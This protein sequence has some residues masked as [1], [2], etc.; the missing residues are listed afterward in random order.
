M[1]KQLEAVQAELDVTLASC[2]EQ[3]AQLE[4]ASQEAAELK[5]C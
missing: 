2:S 5:V 1:R 4:E 3:Q